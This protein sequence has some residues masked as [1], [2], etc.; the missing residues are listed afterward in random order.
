MSSVTAPA[1]VRKSCRRVSPR[2]LS[3]VPSSPAMIYRAFFCRDNRRFRPF[4]I[5]AEAP[6]FGD[7]ETS[8]EARS[9]QALA[10]GP[11]AADARQGVA[12]GV[13]ADRAGVGET[14]QS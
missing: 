2:F 14:A 13:A 4:P 3:T 5:I 7:G 6:Y 9:G 1:E 12:A 11:G 10:Q 8:R